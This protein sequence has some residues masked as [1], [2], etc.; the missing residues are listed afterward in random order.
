AGAPAAAPAASAR[1]AQR[2]RGLGPYR[3]HQEQDDKRGEDEA[4]ELADGQKL[5]MI[6]TVGGRADARSEWRVEP[7]PDEVAQIDLEPRRTGVAGRRH[8]GMLAGAEHDRA[9][10]A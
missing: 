2:D 5:Q 8:F 1:P 10:H 3:E 7:I 4:Q 9:E 6:E